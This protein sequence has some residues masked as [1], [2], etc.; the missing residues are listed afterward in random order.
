MNLVSHEEFAI[1]AS[2]AK[3]V[4]QEKGDATLQP[5][6]FA[7]ATWLVHHKG[8]L[9]SAP[10]LAAHIKAHGDTLHTL[11]KAEGIDDLDLGVDPVP[12]DIKLTL[13]DALKAA[14]TQANLQDDSLFEFVDQLLQRG[15]QLQ[16]QQAVAYHEAGH[17]IVS[18][19]LRPE[20]RLTRA[21]IKPEGH[22]AGSV[23]FQEQNTISNQ[24]DF[25]ERLC[26]AI[27]GQVAQVRKFGANAADAG[28][29]SDFSRATLDAWDYITRFGLDP[30]FGP[31]VLQ[32]LKERGITS[33]WLFDEAQRRLQAVLK[34]AQARTKVIVDTHWDKV[35]RLAILLLEQ[36]TVSEREIRA[37]I[38]M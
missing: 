33:G 35:D 3:A 30:Q 12:A 7:A 38:D 27:A 21:T 14:I 22:S 29:I 26:I 28:A 32:A 19:V 25:L 37:V 23:S 24:E 6:H 16:E 10:T 1:L 5:R 36:E 9:R 18:L 2:Y 13:D 4:A 20:I 17:A 34:E 31:V 8:L 15:I 11:L